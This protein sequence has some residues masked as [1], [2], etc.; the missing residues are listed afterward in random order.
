ME[1][2]K[3]CKSCGKHELSEDSLFEVCPIC[4][5]ESDPVQE[6]NPDMEG[7]ANELSLNQYKEKI[8]D[9]N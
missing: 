8:K 7:G 2:K 9:V 1:T 3:M 5:W 4:G 6:L